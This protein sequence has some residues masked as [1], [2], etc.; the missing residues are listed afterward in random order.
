MYYTQ[1]DTLKKVYQDPIHASTPANYTY[2][3]M[4]SEVE[5][6]ID[7]TSSSDSL[8]FL[9]GLGGVKTKVTF[10]SLDLLKGYLINKAELEVYVSDLGGGFNLYPAP[11]QLIASYKNASGSI[12]LIQ[13][14]SQAIS[15]G[16]FAGI[17][18]GNVTGTGNLR[19]YSLNITNHIKN[20]LKDSTYN[21]DLYLNVYT[22]S[23]IVNRAVIYGAKHSTFPMKLNISYTKI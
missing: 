21:S 16:S 17:F 11:V 7:G 19:K 9:Q 14:V 8:S 10:D 4:G 2:D 22:E 5:K 3:R 15:I 12:Q 1:N 6:F 18:G 20:S 13:D 23:E